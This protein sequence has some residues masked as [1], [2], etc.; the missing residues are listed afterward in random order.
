MRTGTMLQLMLL[1]SLTLNAAHLIAKTSR[2]I[3][4]AFPFLLTY[5]GAV[6]L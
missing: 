4:C 1:L 6:H 5:Q 3:Y 2:N